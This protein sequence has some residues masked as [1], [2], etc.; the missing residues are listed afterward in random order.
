[1]LPDLE[2]AR[3][4]ALQ[5]DVVHGWQPWSEDGGIT[6]VQGMHVASARR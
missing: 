4:A 5:D 2:P 6:Y 3:K 1:M